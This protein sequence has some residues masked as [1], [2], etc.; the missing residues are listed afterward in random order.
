[1]PFAKRERDESDTD[2]DEPIE[3]LNRNW[4]RW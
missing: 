3:M 1:M 2:D 4:S